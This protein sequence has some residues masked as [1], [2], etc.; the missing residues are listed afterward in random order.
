MATKPH[1][2]FEDH[3]LEA[4]QFSRSLGVSVPKFEKTDTRLLTSTVLPQLDIY[5][6][7]FM[8]DK[9]PSVFFSQCIN[10]H[11]ALAKIMKKRLNLH[12]MFTIGSIKKGDSI[13]F[14]LTQADV[15]TWA[16][17]GV[18]NPFGLSLHAWLTLPSMEII[19]FTLRPS[20]IINNGL[21]R[22]SLR[23]DA[24]HWRDFLSIEYL[25]IATGEDLL[26]KLGFRMFDAQVS[27][28][29]DFAPH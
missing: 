21:N 22:D 11:L 5:F 12:P 13:G 14:P 27:G 26:E 29:D 15:S 19:D 9:G 28:F 10:I 17:A 25:P 23:Y 6:L 3:F 24:K 16:R 8:E 1:L 4:V 18:G 20:V 2:T 7:K